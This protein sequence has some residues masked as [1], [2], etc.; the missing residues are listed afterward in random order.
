MDKIKPE[1]AMWETR[2]YKRMPISK[3][4]QMSTFRSEK[5]FNGMDTSGE[6]K[7]TTS[8]EKDGHGHT[9]EE[10][11]GRT[12]RRW[13]DNIGED[14]KQYDMTADMNENRQHCKMIVKTGPQRCAV[15]VDAL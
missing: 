4:C 6:E 11:K 5:R 14:M 1:R 15:S 12:R 7:K 13:I 10:K 3:V 9:G 2:S 8:Q